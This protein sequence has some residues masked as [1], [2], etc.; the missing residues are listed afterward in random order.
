MQALPGKI[1]RHRDVA[2]FAWAC[3]RTLGRSE[4][5]IRPGTR[6]LPQRIDNRI[7]QLQRTKVRVSDQRMP[8]A[9]IA[10][11]RRPGRKM[12]RP[13]DSTDSR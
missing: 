12:R 6:A 8:P 2:P 3:T 13:V 5:N 10:S 9:E 4:R 11:E 7:L 1:E